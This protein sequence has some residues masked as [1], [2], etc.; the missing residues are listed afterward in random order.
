M[1]K[2][3]CAYVVSKLECWDLNDATEFNERFH[4]TGYKNRKTDQAIIQLFCI[5]IK[6]LLSFPE[7]LFGAVQ[8]IT[9]I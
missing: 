1:I 8:Y 3:F 9:S 5:L 4:R 7:Y 2:S 6:L